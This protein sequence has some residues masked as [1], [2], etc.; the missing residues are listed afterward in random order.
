MAEDNEDFD[1]TLEELAEEQRKAAA[2]G[3]VITPPG[4][5]AADVEAEL[6]KE[7]LRRE[8]EERRQKDSKGKGASPKANSN[9]N[10]TDRSLDGSGGPPAV[11][12]RT[13]RPLAP[14]F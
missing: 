7:A 1:E 3:V 6:A 11:P 10:G 2:L 5:L 8:D 13:P 4:S 14:R 9:G 12:A